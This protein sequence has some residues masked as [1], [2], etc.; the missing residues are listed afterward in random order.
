MERAALMA[1]SNERALRRRLDQHH[2]TLGRKS[3]CPIC[4]EPTK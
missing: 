3:T 4:M 1:E 2:L